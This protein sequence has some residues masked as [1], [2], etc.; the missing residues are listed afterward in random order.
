[1]N[2]LKLR[3]KEDDLAV[4]AVVDTMTE[5]TE[6]H[7]TEV[8]RKVT[9]VDTTTIEATIEV[10]IEVVEEVEVNQVLEKEIHMEIELIGGE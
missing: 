6:A 5:T 9:E 8:E 1:M 2:E 7:I 10:M 3:P 4:V